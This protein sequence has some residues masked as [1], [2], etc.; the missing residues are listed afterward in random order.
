M[1]NL[2]LIS[3][4]NADP[5]ARYLRNALGGAEI[6][7]DVAPYGQ[8]YQTLSAAPDA[9]NRWGS[10][11]WTR[12]E[13]VIPVFA[14]ALNL[15]EVDAARCLKEVDVFAESLLNFAPSQKHNFVA[16]WVMPPDHRG[17]G[18]LDWQ[19]DVGLANLLARM[20]LRL[21][22]RIAEARNIHLLDTARWLHAAPRAAAPKMWYAAKVPYVNAVFE[23]AANDLTAAML[24]LEGR[25]RR[26]LVIDLDNTL[27]GGVVGET[28]W[29]GIRLGG[30]DHVGEAFRDFQNALA[31]LTN[32]GVQLAIVS[33]NDE[34]VALEAIDRHP[35]M[36]LRRGHF[37]GWRINWNDKAENI[38]ALVNE[39]NLG[40]ASV[41]FIDDNP[42]ERDRVRNALPEVLVPEWPVD[43]AA[44]ASTLHSL[45]CF[46]TAGLSA[47]DRGRTAMY[48]ADRERREIGKTVTSGDEWL[49]RLD[50]R[51]QVHH[52]GKANIA[53]VAQLFNKTNQ[54]NLSTRRLTEQE[55]LD[56][57]GQ[58]KHALLTVSAADRFGDM[59]L[60]GIV[61]LEV[62]GQKGQLVDFILSC[63][64][65][66]RKV[67][68][69]MYHLAAAE[70]VR[71]GATTLESRYLP[72]ARNRPTLDIFRGFALAEPVEH[73]F[74]DDRIADSVKPDAVT[75]EFNA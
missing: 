61:G 44:Y 69:T 2:R 67:E 25:S 41:V 28:G 33:K 16:A 63:R 39:L 4:F 68:E 46:E 43:P 47:E 72:T 54:L 30:H 24:A 14:E 1:F 12:A 27:W 60:V 55:I 35:E 53:R 22:E 65:M 51:L 10:M 64:V 19:G 17:Y 21:A 6:A 7:V 49:R 73:I 71:L 23:N 29:E 9:G 32:R 18:M 75:V 70:A 31:A 26:I 57:A 66:G 38:A 8:V 62:E 36:I 42:A 74:V 5:L 50:T 58:T 13:A 45:N 40:L 11:V 48:A 56:W 59:G 34:S 15:Q 3:D 37:A 20:N 52:A